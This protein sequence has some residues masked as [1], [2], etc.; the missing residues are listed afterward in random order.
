M[1]PPVPRHSSRG[2]RFYSPHSLTWTIPFWVSPAG[3]EAKVTVGGPILEDMVSCNDNI[4]ALEPDRLCSTLHLPTTHSACDQIH[5]V[6]AHSHVSTQAHYCGTPDKFSGFIH[7]YLRH[8]LPP[9]HRVPVVTPH[10]LVKSSLHV[11]LQPR[12]TLPS[13]LLVPDA[14]LSFEIHLGGHPC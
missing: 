11:F 2:L 10:A 9:S 4:L 13:L 12:L 5:Q 3:S 14:C 6:S 8:S 1:G 7:R